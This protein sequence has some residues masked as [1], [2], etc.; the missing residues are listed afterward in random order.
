MCLCVSKRALNE[1]IKRKSNWARERERANV[2]VQ[3]LSGL[4]QVDQVGYR[5]IGSFANRS[6]I[7]CKVESVRERERERELEVALELESSYSMRTPDQSELTTLPQLD[8][9]LDAFFLRQK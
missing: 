9:L 4:D 2:S 5:R 7:K 8:N 3:I 6:A 1:R